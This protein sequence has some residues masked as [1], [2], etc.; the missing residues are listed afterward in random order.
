MLSVYCLP[1]AAPPEDLRVAGISDRSI[2]LEWDG[3][4]AVTEYVISYQPM[5]PGGLQLQQRVPGDWRGVTVTELEPGLTYNISVYAVISN[6]LSLPITAKVATRTYHVPS[7][8]HCSFLPHEIMG[9]HH[10]TQCLFFILR[11]HLQSSLLRGRAS[12]V[13]HLGEGT[14]LNRHFQLREFPGSVSSHQ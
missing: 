5:A 4:M 10:N 7:L 3:P 13:A 14:A 11:G 12:D 6:I 9:I 8:L 1:V 2:E